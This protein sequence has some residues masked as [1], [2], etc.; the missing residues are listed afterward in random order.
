MVNKQLNIKLY[1]LLIL[2]SKVFPILIALCY[3]LNVVLSYFGMNDVPLNYL[4][5]MSF[6]PLLYLYITSYTL[7]LC[8][9]HR[10]YLH[11]IVI[12]DII[13]ILD[14]YQFIPLTNL[15]YMM[16][17]LILFILAMFIILYLKLKKI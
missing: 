11:Y 13:N 3:L 6:I 15:E 1:K 14:F 5:G 17:F 7:K 12:V 10:I 9:Y 4:G 8:N 2:S 16:L